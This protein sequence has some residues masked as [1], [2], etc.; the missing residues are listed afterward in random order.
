[1]V[2]YC[3][4]AVIFAVSA[5]TTGF[6]LRSVYFSQELVRTEEY[7]FNTQY[8]FEIFQA[9]SEEDQQRL[10]EDNMQI[11]EQMTEEQRI[12]RMEQN[13]MRQQQQNALNDIQGQIDELEYMIRAFDEQRQ[14]IID[15]LSSRSIIPPVAAIFDAMLES[16]A[17]LMGYSVLLSHSAYYESYDPYEHAEADFGFVMFTTE[18]QLSVTEA[19]LHERI[20]LL[21][22]ELELQVLLLEDVQS[23]HERMVPHIRNFPT[24]WPITAQ[25]S[26]H[27]GWRANPM[28]GRGSEFHYGIDLR[29][30]TGTPIRA[31]GGG[32]VTFQGWQGGFGN[33]VIISHGNGIETL[34]AHNSVNLVSVGQR[35]ERGDIIARVGTTGRTTGAHLH[36]EIR[37]NGSAVNPRPYML[38]H[39]N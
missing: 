23:Y 12:A 9:Q 35:V 31:A 39:W 20:A 19:E 28:G 5:V 22:A 24:L 3:V 7:L 38:E 11:Y 10:M 18:P 1:V 33:V 21:M 14:S 13:F 30:P 16:Q 17:A 8:A 37:I 6:Y 36:Y 29:S 27:F 25:I 26:S 34:Y 15:E 32:T 4:L 2:F